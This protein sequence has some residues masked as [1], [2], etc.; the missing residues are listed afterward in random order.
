MSAEH[1]AETQFHLKGAY[2]PYVYKRQRTL[3]CLPPI[4]CQIGANHFKL[5]VYF[6]S[7]KV[8]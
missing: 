5:L 7:L 8:L 3:E 1:V 4:F 6:L 2:L